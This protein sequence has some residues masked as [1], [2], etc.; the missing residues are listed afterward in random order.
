VS[1]YTEE[2]YTPLSIYC[3][4]F[5][6]TVTILDIDPDSGNIRLLPTPDEAYGIYIDNVTYGSDSLNIVFDFRGDNQTIQNGSL[7]DFYGTVT[8]NET[9]YSIRKS[10]QVNTITSAMEGL[11]GEL[12]QLHKEIEYAVVGSDGNFACKFRYQIHRTVGS[13]T[14]VIIP[15]D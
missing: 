9:N 13:T 10:L 6:R 8:I 12:W 15:S 5:G 7:I 1:I 4:L 11:D 3:D 14:E 2:S